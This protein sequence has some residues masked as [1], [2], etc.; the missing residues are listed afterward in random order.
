MGDQTA[1]AW[2]DHTFNPWWGCEKVSPGC[3]HCYAE[4]LA[5]RF[6]PG[7][8]LWGPGRTFRTFGDA[9]WRL[10]LKWD[11]AAAKAGRRARVFCASMADVFDDKAPGI[12]RVKL[13]AAIRKT[14]NLDWLLLT[15]RPENFASLLP[16]DWGDGWPNVWLGTSVE[17]QQYADER[18]PHL[19]AT[20]AAVRFL[21]CEPL[22]APVDLLGVRPDIWR[23][24]PDAMDG[25]SWVIVGG[26]SGD[27]F[28]AMDLAALEAIVEQ[29]RAANVAV[30]VKQDSSKRSET[31]G[32]IP[33]ELWIKEWPR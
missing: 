8:K 4:T 31:K 17:S 12:E 27:D 15:K 1:I 30:F 19:L 28:R 13:W 14:P 21:S 20:P 10:P 23:T 6:A 3:K 26:E 11:R 5:K 16:V 29:C 18:I 33:D 9:Y 32:R 25:I 7:M 22:L 2:A 24:R